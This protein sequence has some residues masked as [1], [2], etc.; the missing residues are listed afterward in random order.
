MTNR[1]ETLVSRLLRQYALETLKSYGANLTAVTHAIEADWL[2]DV[3]SEQVQTWTDSLQ[4]A[5]TETGESTKDTFLL[6]YAL[7]VPGTQRG[8]VPPLT[9]LDENRGGFGPRRHREAVGCITRLHEAIALGRVMIPE[10]PVDTQAAICEL[11]ICVADLQPASDDDWF[12]WYESLDEDQSH[13]LSNQAIHLIDNPVESV[14]E[15]GT[16]ILKDIAG[17]REPPLPES[18]LSTLMAR[19][20]FWPSSLYR[21]GGDEVADQLISL[22]GVDPDILHLN[23]LLLAIAWTRCPKAKE[24]FVRWATDPQDWSDMLHVPAV[25]YLP[26]AGWTLEEGEETRSL[27]STRCFRLTLADSPAKN[28][29]TCRTE[30]DGRCPAC[31]G[32]LGWLFDFTS[33]DL[34]KQAELFSEDLSGAPRRILCC[35]HCACYET[36]LT[37]Y[38]P[39][40]D[41]LWIA[42]IECEFEN[43]GSQWNTCIREIADRPTSPFA[44]SEPF[45][46]EDSSTLGGMPSWLQDAE[47]PRCPECRRLMRFLAQH[48]NGALGEEGLYYAFFCGDCSVASVSYQQT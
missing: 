47:F 7:T 8:V 17:Y 6:R 5:V 30:S 25:D 33:L 9:A 24:A 48:D 29:I 19:E 13:A 21:D 27:I 11:A 14:R 3:E 16:T 43:D 20:V 4:Q 34:E 35:F 31:E 15:L 44:A 38:G 36:V 46:L 22:I 26:S 41:E 1:D 12:R 45:A 23:H 2:P 28:R 40:M 42:P 10:L 39:D 18:V 32:A 37:K